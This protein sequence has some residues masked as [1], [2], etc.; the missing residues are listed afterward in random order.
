MTPVSDIDPSAPL[1]RMDGRVALVAGASRGLGEAVAE[2]LALAGAEVVLVARTQGALEAL[3]DRIGAAGGKAVIAPVD[4]TDGEAVD[5]LAGGIATRYGK[6]DALVSTAAILGQLSP[7]AHIP[8]KVFEKTLATN[9]TAH[10]RLIRNFEALLQRSDAGRA[11]VVTSGAAQG[12]LAFWAPYAASKAALEA[13]VSCWAEEVRQTSLR[14]N[15]LDP[16]VMA[17]GLRAEAFPGEDPATLRQPADI[18]PMAVRLAA[19]SCDIHGQAV[20]A[21]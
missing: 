12:G 17:T 13:M 11:V 14:I 4:L 15:L 21:G 5:R 2:A 10:W 9:V 3:H 6:L 8:P 19:A 7:I 18:A 16:G 1:E 20:R